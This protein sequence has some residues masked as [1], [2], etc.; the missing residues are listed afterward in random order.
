MVGGSV[1]SGP[2][3]DEPRDGR[4]LSSVT[5]TSSRGSLLALSIALAGLPACDS[6]E[7]TVKAGGKAARDASDK[8]LDASKDKASELAD[9]AAD[10]ASAL[11][12]EALDASK[13]A[14]VDTV[15]ASKKAAADLAAATRTG[16]HELFNDLRDDGQLSA[17]TKAWLHTQ[18]EDASASIEN[19][20][21]TGVQLAPVAVE[22]SKVL[23]D[24]VDSDTA[25]EPIFQRVTED[26]AKVDAAIGDMPRVEVVEDVTV[27]FKQFDALTGSEQIKQRGY[28]VMWRHED[29]LVGFVYRSTRTID[30]DTLVAE[31]PRLIRLT[32]KALQD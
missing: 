11:G 7:Q 9:K 20:V 28:L 5:M 14:A 19:V 16:A 4:L 18:A 6:A 32:Q 27:G 22:A 29:H 10:K 30:L 23:I 21:V 31:T 3:A 24:A 8:A 13:K 12:D 2:G 26:P 15:E 17:S 1:V 25:I